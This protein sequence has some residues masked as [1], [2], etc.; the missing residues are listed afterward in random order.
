MLDIP[1]IKDILSSHPMYKM[2][3]MQYLNQTIISDGIADSEYEVFE[4]VRES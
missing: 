1:N 4:R 2:E 3:F